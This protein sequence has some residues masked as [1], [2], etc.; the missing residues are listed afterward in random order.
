MQPYYDQYAAPYVDAA[1]PYYRTA[2][3]NV[4]DPAQ[5]YAVHYATPWVESGRQYAWAQWETNGQPRLAHVQAAALAQYDKSVAPHVAD[6][7]RVLE[8]Y[9]NIAYANAQV[10]FD[11][12]ILPAYEFTK[13]YA[14]RGYDASYNFTTIT[15]FPA[16]NW[17]WNKTN[18]FLDTAVWPQL[19]IVYVENVEPQLVRIG[20]RLGRY[21]LRPRIKTHR[22]S[23]TT[24]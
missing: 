20:E 11:K 22:E 6:A 4:F 12:A 9:Y 2:K 21:K 10:A 7:S 8:P 23:A 14:I 16:V 5:H 1:Q 15:V 19:R 18:A 24:R 17:G 3:V 13:P